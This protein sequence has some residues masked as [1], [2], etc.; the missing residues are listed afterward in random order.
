MTDRILAESAGNPLAIIELVRELSPGQLRGDEPLPRDLPDQRTGWRPASFDG[1][2]G[3]PA[4]RSSCCSSPRPRRPP[5]PAS[6][7]TRRPPWVCDGTVRHGTPSSDL[8]VFH[9]EV[10]FRH[11]LVRSAIYDGAS[12]DDRRRVHEA[13]AAVFDRD[14]QPD[15]W[16]WHRAAAADGPTTRSPTSWNA[17]RRELVDGAAPSAEAALLARSAELTVDAHRRSTR[18][19]AAADAA[20]GGGD[21]AVADE[22]ALQHVA[23]TFDDPLLE[24]QVHRLVGTLL[25]QRAE[26]L[27]AMAAF[28]AASALFEQVDPRPGP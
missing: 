21:L 12:S 9:P 3:F 11:P 7:A 18:W 23:T 5:I 14:G 8:L 1:L 24:G 10:S 22:A 20:L 16:A 28:L 15:R 2:V 17:S 25:V 6:S 26:H 4:T 19:M 13:L 27:E